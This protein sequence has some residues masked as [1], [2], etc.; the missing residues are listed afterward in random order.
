MSS[1]AYGGELVGAFANNG[2]MVG[3]PFPIGNG[4]TMLTIPNGATELMMG[5]N[6]NF[7]SDNQGSYTVTV[8]SVDVP[9]YQVCLLYDTTKAVKSGST[10]PVKLQ[11]CNATGGNV[12]SADIIAH[13]SSITLTSTSTSG[14]VQDAGNANPDN[15]FRYDSMLGGSGGYIFNLRTNGLGTGTYQLSFTVTGDS[16]IYSAPLQVK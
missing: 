1:P 9:K 7:F 8:A 12:S 5:V 11:L 16:F 10:L 15:D 6:D 14:D 4:P 13:A 3:T 2:V